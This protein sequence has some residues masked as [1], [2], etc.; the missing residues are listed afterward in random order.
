M[1]LHLSTAPWRGRWTNDDFFAAA[2]PGF[3]YANYT[4][5][6]T[7]LATQALLTYRAQDRPATP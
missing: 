1:P 4:L 6:P 7:F 3:W 5:M 2:L